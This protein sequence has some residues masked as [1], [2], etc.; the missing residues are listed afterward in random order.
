M[1]DAAEGTV[2]GRDTNGPA[3]SSRRRRIDRWGIAFIVASVVAFVALLYLGRSVTFYH[4]DWTFI[5]TRLGW[6][7]DTFMRPHNEHWVLVPALLWK[8]L[9]ATVGFQSYL[10]YLA[11]NFAAHVATAAAIYWGVRRIAGPAAGLVLGVLMLSLGSGAELFFHAA[12]ANLVMAT[13]AGAWA[14]MITIATDRPRPLL[15]AVLLLVGVASGGPGLFFVA[16]VAVYLLFV[17]GRWRQGWVVMPALGSYVVW[18][19]VYGRENTEVAWKPTLGALVELWD[20]VR[21]GATG[22]VAGVTALG[23]E[24]GMIVLAILVLATGWQLLGRGPYLYAAL[25]ALA[26]LAAQNIVTGLVRV[27]EAGSPPDAPRY[28]YTGAV[29]VMVALA[30]WYGSRPR[31]RPINALPLLAIAAWAIVFNLFQ[32]RW[33]ADDWYTVRSQE[34]RAAIE[35]ALEYGGTELLPGDQRPLHPSDPFLRALPSADRLREII[36]TLPG[37]PLDDAWQPGSY[38]VP[39]EIRE[40]I[41]SEILDVHR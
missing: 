17:P 34:T 12:G 20:F 41:E 2:L 28:V 25:A 38:A 32:V 33:W 16:A 29:F 26:G 8:S 5:D 35:V 1:S 31:M 7:I 27:G 22:A 40:R 39:A 30:A 19:T 14:L 21:V 6:S 37:T 18:L 24:I 36:D 4:D 10:P 9:L 11:I 23:S 13:A 15:V 3:T